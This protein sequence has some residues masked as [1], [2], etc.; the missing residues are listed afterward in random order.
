MELDE[1]K[2][3]DFKGNF[4]F[5]KFHHLF[6]YDATYYSYLIA[7]VA[8]QKL[9]STQVQSASTDEHVR[10]SKEIVHMFERGAMVDSKML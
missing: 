6:E 5:N 8:S 7:K 3:K 1:E 10:V 2:V 4:L 9:Y